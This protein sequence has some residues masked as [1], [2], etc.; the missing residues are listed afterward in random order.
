MSQE[1]LTVF[2]RLEGRFAETTIKNFK[3]FFKRV[4]GIADSNNLNLRKDSKQVIV[5]VANEFDK[6]ST[7][8]T[9]LAPI[10]HY[11]QLLGESKKRHFLVYRDR[12]DDLTD[13]MEAT[14]KVLTVRQ[15]NTDYQKLLSTFIQFVDDNQFDLSE[16]GRDYLLFSFFILLPPRR[17][18]YVEMVYENSFK[19]MNKKTNYLIESSHSWT[20]VFNV[21]KTSKGFKQQKFKIENPILIKILENEEFTPGKRIYGKVKRSFQ[22]GFKKI[23][24]KFSGQELSIQDIRILHSSDEFA[25]FVEFIERLKRDSDMMAHQISTKIKT[26]IRRMN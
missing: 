16:M 14:P 1:E 13:E 17:L 7:Q 24:K 25:N 23:A 9:M 26:Y 11:F 22:R 3:R 2:D 10:V 21:F 18:D 15:S 12:V 5:E 19:K 8:R 4:K 20:F 6:I